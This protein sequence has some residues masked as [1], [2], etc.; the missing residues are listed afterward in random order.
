MALGQSFAAN[1]S[2]SFGEDL[3]FLKK[4]TGILLPKVPETGGRAAIAAA[5]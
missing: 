5:W 4:H 3:A 1:T 2:P